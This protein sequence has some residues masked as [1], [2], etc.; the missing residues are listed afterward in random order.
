MGTAVSQYGTDLS[1]TAA[2]APAKAPA[3]VGYFATDTG[4]FMVSEGD[5]G[6]RNVGAPNAA[7]AGATIT[8]GAEAANVINVAIQ[9]TDAA[10]DALATVGHVVAFLSDASTGIGITA[11]APDADV[12]IGTDGAILWEFVTDKAFMLQSEADGDIDLDIGDATGT[13]TWYLVVLLPNGQKVISDA[14]TFA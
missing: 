6:F 3:G 10:G 14:I 2:N 13:P 9:L 1:G 7:V 4:Q 11:A 8:V 5:G 12:A